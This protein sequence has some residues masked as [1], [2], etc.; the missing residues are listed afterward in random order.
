MTDFG[1]SA[2][3]VVVVIVVTA[4]VCML[5]ASLVTLGATHVRP[6]EVPRYEQLI[7]SRASLNLP[8]PRRTAPVAP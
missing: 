5:V 2:Q 8:R 1:V 6:R 3:V 4:L 7:V